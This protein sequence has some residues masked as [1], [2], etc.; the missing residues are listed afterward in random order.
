MAVS[1]CPPYSVALLSLAQVLLVLAEH[2]PVQERLL[3]QVAPQRL[4]HS[5]VQ[6]WAVLPAALRLV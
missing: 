3:E 4:R 5:P 6:A 2:P 1:C